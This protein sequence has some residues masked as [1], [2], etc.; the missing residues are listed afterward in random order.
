MVE[1]NFRILLSGMDYVGFKSM[2]DHPPSRTSIHFVKKWV[3]SWG[4]R[5]NIEWNPEG[6]VN[7]Y[8]VKYPRVAY[9]KYAVK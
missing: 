6:R 4:S 8:R 9:I 2:V 3:K 5:K 7:K 1:E